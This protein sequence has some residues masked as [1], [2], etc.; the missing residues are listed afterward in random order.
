MPALKSMH[1]WQCVLLLLQEAP[2]GVVVK[3][4]QRRKGAKQRQLPP[5]VHTAQRYYHSKTCMPMTA[6]EVHGT[7]DSDDEEDIEEWK[8]SSC[9]FLG[10]VQLQYRDSIPSH[11]LRSAAASSPCSSGSPMLMVGRFVFAAAA[12]A[13]PEGEAGAAVCVE[14]VHVQLEHVGA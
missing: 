3:P 7:V 4:V 9:Q 2:A 1:V 12:A 14:G 6:A 5:L 11:A 10:L 8:V 13:Q